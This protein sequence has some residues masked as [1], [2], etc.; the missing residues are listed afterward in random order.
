MAAVKEMGATDEF[1]VQMA[2]FATVDFMLEESHGK[3]CPDVKVDL[4]RGQLE[5]SRTIK[6]LKNKVWR[7][8]PRRTLGS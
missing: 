5:F 4:K 3:Q 2:L 1:A 7:C 8:T 6:F